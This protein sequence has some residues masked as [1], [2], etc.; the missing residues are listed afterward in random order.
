MNK[1]SKIE[2]KECALRK[3]VKT[4]G[5]GREGMNI[6]MGVIIDLT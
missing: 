6:F 4:E 1:E 5:A 2:K 3:T